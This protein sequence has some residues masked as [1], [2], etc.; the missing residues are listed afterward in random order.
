MYIL[1]LTNGSLSCGSQTK[2]I[3]SVLE[4]TFILIV[5]LLRRCDL[6]AITVLCAEYKL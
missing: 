4:S 3:Y 5:P 2:T 1:D 6:T